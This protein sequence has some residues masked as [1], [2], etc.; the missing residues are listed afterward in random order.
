MSYKHISA[1]GNLAVAPAGGKAKLTTVNVNTAADSAVFT[2]YNGISASGEVV[3]VIDASETCSR[4]YAFTLND[5]IF[6]VL[7]GGNADVTVGYM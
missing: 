1:A 6:C 3:A 4:V 7:S 5:G 2:I